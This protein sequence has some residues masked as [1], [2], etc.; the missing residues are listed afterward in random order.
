MVA[1][2][3]SSQ[4]TFYHSLFPSWEGRRPLSWFFAEHL[5]EARADSDFPT[6]SR[7]PDE[8]VNV[9]L[10]NLLGDWV[11]GSSNAGITEGADS[12]VLPF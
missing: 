10:L 9:Y 3:Q 4:D 2:A 12:L 6:N 7:G 8:D 5:L 11:D 1:V